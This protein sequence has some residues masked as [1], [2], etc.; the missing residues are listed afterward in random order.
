MRSEDEI[1]LGPMQGFKQTVLNSAACLT[2]KK[3]ETPPLFKALDDVSFSIE[4]GEMVGQHHRPPWR[5]QIHLAQNVGRHGS[6]RVK[7]WN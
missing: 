7:R 5:G 1:R 3:L 6:S 4:P 2:G